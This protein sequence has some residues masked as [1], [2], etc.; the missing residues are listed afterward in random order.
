MMYL[1]A[2][3]KNYGK[4]GEYAKEVFDKAQEIASGTEDVA[5]R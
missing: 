4:A 1:E 3:Q 2:M 5:L